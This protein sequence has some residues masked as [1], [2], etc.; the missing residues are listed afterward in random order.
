MEKEQ[1]VEDLAVHEDN[2]PAHETASFDVHDPLNWSMPQKMLVLAV[3]CLWIFTGT[4]NG[5]IN[6]S[7]FY[8]IAGEFSV[9]VANTSYLIGGPS[10]TYGVGSIFWVAFGNRYGVRLTFVLTSVAAACMSFWGAKATTFG[11]LMAARVL[12][13]LF[14]ASPETLGPQVAGDVFLLKDRAK[15][16]TCIV[17]FQGAGYALGPLFGAYIYE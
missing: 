6:G 11:S 15:A 2:V 7:A 3:L 16:V 1:Y 5:L 14:Y 8:T 12:S 13:A 10:L 4:T 17:V 9:P